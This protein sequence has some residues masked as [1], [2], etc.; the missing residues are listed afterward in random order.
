MIDVLDR[1]VNWLLA[2]V[3]A[4]CTVNLFGRDA[5]LL[6]R[7]VII[8][9]RRLNFRSVRHINQLERML[10]VVSGNRA[11]LSNFALLSVSLALI[12]LIIMVSLT[13]S[14]DV[15]IVLASSG[16]GFLPLLIQWGRLQSIRIK[17]SYEGLDLVTTLYNN[18]IICSSN[19]IFALD[20]TV[21]ALKKSPYSKYNLARLS[22][23]IKAYKTE[24]DLQEAVD[25]FAYSYRT[26]WANILSFCIFI[27]VY[28]GTNITAALESLV[29]QFKR[30]RQVMERNKRYNRETFVLMKALIPVAYFGLLYYG[31]T[32]FAK[33]FWQIILQQFTNPMGLKLFVVMAVM[34]CGCWVLSAIISRPKYDL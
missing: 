2:L 21:P 26:E 19:I 6:I 4:A 15:W 20:M 25:T 34:A 17:G 30:V 1:I 24:Y 13:G 11:S 31:S 3:I 22:K 7:D 10:A 14:I 18:Y 12:I 8:P 9:R 28:E 23:A 32:L 5:Y 29:E 16:I 33:S 27:G